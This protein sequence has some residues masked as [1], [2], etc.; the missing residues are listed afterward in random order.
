M[1][2]TTEVESRWLRVAFWI[3]WSLLGLGFLGV[4]FYLD[5]LTPKIYVLI[6]VMLLAYA[7][8]FYENWQRLATLRQP[9]Q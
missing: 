9:E 2:P 5:R 8:A 7:L 3:T 4:A 1:W 6:W